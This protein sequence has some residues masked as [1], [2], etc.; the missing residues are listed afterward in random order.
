MFPPNTTTTQCV[1]NNPALS[2]LKSWAINQH[3]CRE[4][5]EDSQTYNFVETALWGI[6][7]K[8]RYWS[9]ESDKPHSAFQSC[10][11]L[12]QSSWMVT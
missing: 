3:V 7:M 1:R 2:G 4:E 5:L 11:V 6:E 12:A 10:S 9:G 8:G